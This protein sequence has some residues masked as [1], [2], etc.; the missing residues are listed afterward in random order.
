VIGT[1][2]STLS[3]VYAKGSNLSLEPLDYGDSSLVGY[4]PL[5]E[6]TGTI[7]YDYSGNNASG[8]W[9][10]SQVGASGYYSA[11]K[12][13]PWAGTFNGVNDYIPITNL[14]NLSGSQITITA[15]FKGSYAQSIVRYQSGSGNYVVLAWNGL[16]ILSNDGGTASGLSDGSVVDGAWHF[17][18][19]TWIQNSTNGFA[20]YRDGALVASRNSSNSPLPNIGVPVYIGSQGGVAEFTNGSIDDVRI[21][22]RA[23]SASEIAAMYAG[24]K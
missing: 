9:N 12:I 2:G 24:G 6:G 10:G 8:T 3:T 7:A 21:Y 4:W 23:L 13:G 11:G 5:T 22:N 18:A 20:S 16:D 14:T 15:W 19:M 17:M 1:D